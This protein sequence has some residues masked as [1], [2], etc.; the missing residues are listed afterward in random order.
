MKNLDSEKKLNIILASAS[1]RRKE[2]LG[3]LF[4]N[5]EIIPSKETEILQPNIPVDDQAETLAKLKAV[6]VAKNYQDSLVIGCDT[7]VVVD[8]KILG[9]PKNEKDAKKMLTTL[10]DRSHNV[11]T[12]CCMCYKGKM[13]SFS[14]KTEVVFRKLSEEEIDKYITTGEPM[15]KAGAYGI[16]GAGALLVKKINGDFFNVVGFPLSS[17]NQALKTFY[18]VA[19]IS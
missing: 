6:S 1:P 14:E 9:K 11:I 13:M 3:L 18:K 19:F 5:F 8:N 16:Q 7:I 10:S 4:K 17:F 15:D 12:G 2:I